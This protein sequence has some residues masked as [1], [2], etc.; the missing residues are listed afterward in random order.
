MPQYA[1]I[2]IATDT[3]AETA[4][5]ERDYFARHMLPGKWL[6]KSVTWLPDIAVTANGTNY[7]VLTLTNAT[8]SQTIGTRSY[9]A[10]DSVAGTPETVTLPTGLAAVVN[11]GDVLKLAKTTPGTGV[12]IRGK[13]IVELEQAPLP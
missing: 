13:M 10:T 2:V 11:D 12:A 5:T 1:Q 6:I 3:A 9:I 4:D 7:S 8:A